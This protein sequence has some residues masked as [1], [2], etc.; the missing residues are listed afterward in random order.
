MPTEWL[1]SITDQLHNCAVKESL[2]GRRKEV[3]LVY[4]QRNKS[5]F[6]NF[7]KTQLERF[8]INR[9][10]LSGSEFLAIH[11]KDIFCLRSSLGDKNR[12]RE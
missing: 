8:G 5:K 2:K 7:A 12:R 3:D 1:T 4:T 10:R 9:M 11:F 6:E